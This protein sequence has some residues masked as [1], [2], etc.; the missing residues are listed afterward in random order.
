MNETIFN[1][2]NSF[3]G[4]YE[5]LDI[6][7]VFFSETLGII[8]LLGLLMF[9]FSH[10][11]KGQGFHN[12]T[13]ILTAA[14]FAWVLSW[15]IKHTYPFPRP[16]IALDDVIKLINHGGLD[17]FPS[18]HATF[19]SAIVTALYFYHK[20]IALFYALGALLIGIA[21]IVAGVHW[22]LDIVVGYALG[23]AAA[24][25]VYYTYQAVIDTWKRRR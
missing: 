18:G 4:L 10:E 25:F 24:V 20:K 22:P 7:I 5:W 2:F 19:F 1:Y 3:A 14:L 16:F 11:H 23:A 9:L 21:R 17:S 13:I 15:T 12:V 6:P 8:L